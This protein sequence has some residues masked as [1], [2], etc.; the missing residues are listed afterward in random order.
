MINL[1]MLSKDRSNLDE[2]AKNLSEEDIGG[3]VTLL[4]SKEDDL[5]YPA[6]LLLQRRSEIQ[7][8]VYPY[9]DEFVDK[10]K[11]SNSYQRS[12]GCMLL[13]ENVR[14]DREKRLEKIL[15]SYL[16]HCQ[17]EKFI[18]SRQT[19]QSIRRWL[20]LHPELFPVITET[21]N[22]INIES[23]K[24]TQRKLILTDI[25]EVLLDIQAI[26][27]SKPVSDY[28]FQGLSGGLVDRKMIKRIEQALQG[29]ET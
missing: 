19:I 2:I 23:L 14:W 16:S 3:L 11:D 22:K 7:G 9:W 29:R 8:D 10:L 5:R 15:E 13:A 12:I 24:D 20:P 21:L 28:L 6:F 27:P 4:E 18:T 17:D 1:G 25:F 26:Q